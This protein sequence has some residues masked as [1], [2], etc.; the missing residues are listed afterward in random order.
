MWWLF[1]TGAM[2]E[3]NWN[4]LKKTQGWQ[5][6]KVVTRDAVGQISV[7]TKKLEL[8]ALA[9]LKFGRIVCVFSYAST[10]SPLQFFLYACDKIV[11]VELSLSSV[12]LA[13][14]G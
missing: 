1:I 4:R 10:P 9:F 7:F 6:Y 3:P 13:F 8:A 11:C 5:P 12:G 14:A 2:A